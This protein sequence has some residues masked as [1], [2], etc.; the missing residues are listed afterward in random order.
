M[1]SP[2]SVIRIF[3]A[4]SLVA[5]GGSSVWGQTGKRPIDRVKP[6]V[7][8]ADTTTQKIVGG[9]PAKPGRYP[10]QV[11]L[12]QAGTPAGREHQGQF[13]GGALVDKAW[14]LTAAHCVPD[15]R[16][17]EVDVYIGSTVLPSGQAGTSGQ[18]GVRRH[19]SQ[20]VS[21]QRYDASS[22]DNDIALLKLSDPAPDQLA[23]AIVATAELDQAN[24]K[25]G[26]EVVV[27][28]WGATQEGGSRTPRLM[29]VKVRVQ[30]RALCESNYQ[31]AVPA[32]RITE[33][34]FC[35]GAP[36]GGKDSCQGDSGGF[37]GAPQAEGRFVQL[38][39]VS[40]GVGCA[41]PKLFGVYTRVGNYESWV[42]ETMAAF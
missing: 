4:A 30:D 24:A 19:V 27:I 20:M 22:H 33:N 41:R 5:L 28:G 9:Q 14:V 40:W 23:P 3:G 26:A 37:I 42:K 2:R 38:G 15:T 34:M 29:E 39:V 31:A 21:H 11:A 36:E 1:L 12:I 10:F 25:P 35:A 8:P 18:L 6:G 13:C 17:D 32:A 16:P 7:A